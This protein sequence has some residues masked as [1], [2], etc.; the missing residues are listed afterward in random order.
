MFTGAA[1]NTQNF[2]LWAGSVVQ[3]RDLGELVIVNVGFFTYERESAPTGSQLSDTDRY[4]DL[5]MVVIITVEA[6]AM[7]SRTSGISCLSRLAQYP[8]SYS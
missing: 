3:Q 4:I 1:V 8:N 2:N 7:R 6:A 5:R